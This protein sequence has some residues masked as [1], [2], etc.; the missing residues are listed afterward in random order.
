MKKDNKRY[1]VYEMDTNKNI[2]MTNS[3]NHAFDLRCSFNN[4]DEGLRYSI[5]I[6]YV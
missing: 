5:K 3:F 2:C 4:N 1:I 6:I